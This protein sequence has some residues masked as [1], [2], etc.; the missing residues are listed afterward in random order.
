MCGRYALAADL[1]TIAQEFSAHVSDLHESHTWTPEYNI[2]PTTWAPVIVERH[3]D[4]APPERLVTPARWGLLPPWTRDPAERA[5]LFNARSETVA[6]KRSFSESY[7]HKRCI[8]PAS[9]YFEW[10][11]EGRVKTPYYVHA[12]SLMS[13]AGV[14]SWWKKGDDEW[15]LTYAILTAQAPPS[16]TWLHDRV[17]VMVEAAHQA[18]WLDRDT[19]KD[20]LDAIVAASTPSTEVG[21]T[22]G[23]FT[24]DQVSKD[25][26][27]TRN[28]GAQLIEPV[29]HG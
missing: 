15:W 14:Y 7:A 10:H 25:V 17:P 18:A 21:L 6:E 2:A 29:A 1:A 27:N 22:D 23:Y 8:V 28:H 5:P 20:E 19:P 4:G 12:D 16:L 26:G 9:G 13:M 3:H 24:V 11:T